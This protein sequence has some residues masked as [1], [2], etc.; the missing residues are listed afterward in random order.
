M[1][2]DG[3]KPFLLFIDYGQKHY[4]AEK[5]ASLKCAK[6]IG[7]EP[8]YI[9]EANLTSFFNGSRDNLLRS[10]VQ[11]NEK[12]D[13][14]HYSFVQGRNA[15]MLLRAAMTAS[16]IDACTI[17]IGCNETDVKSGFPDCSLNFLDVMQKVIAASFV[18]H[19]S[20]LSPC[21]SMTK[22]D[23]VAYLKLTLDDKF[24]HIIRESWSCYEGG[25]QPCGK[26][27]A[28]SVRYNALKALNCSR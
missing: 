19:I 13:S 11:Q 28:C 3:Y 2:K 1:I 4:A 22:E 8:N 27:G 24:H 26:C 10:I 16:Q 25:L 20:I 15:A 14:V 23:V 7:I 9:S 18:E 6:I 17:A 21:A 5:H 12:I